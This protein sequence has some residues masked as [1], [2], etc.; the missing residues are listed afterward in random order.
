MDSGWEPCF[1]KSSEEW[2]GVGVD[3]E[4]CYFDCFMAWEADVRRNLRRTFVE[5]PLYSF[6]YSITVRGKIGCI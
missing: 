2:I 1:L 6:S 3:C 4:V 5:K